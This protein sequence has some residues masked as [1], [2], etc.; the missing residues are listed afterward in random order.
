V[1]HTSFLDWLAGFADGE[2]CFLIHRRSGPS[3]TFWCGFRI[4]LRGDDS[5]I[6]RRV[7]AQLGVGHVYLLAARGNRRPAVCW[8]VRGPAG[9]L[10]LVE[11]FD[12]HPLRAKKARDYGV[13]RAAVIYHAR[14]NRG[15]GHK[16]AP[17]FLERMEMY[18]AELVTGRLYGSAPIIAGG[19]DAGHRAEVVATNAS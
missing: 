9:C 15:N 18:R 19:G 1:E 8:E 6:L 10:K 5:D 3:R 16:S 14:N 12:Q 7:R 17:E 4:T 11:V 2:G 13:W